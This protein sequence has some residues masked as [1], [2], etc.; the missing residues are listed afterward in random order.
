M[1]TYPLADAPVT[2]LSATDGRP[3]FIVRLGLLLPCTPEDVES[4]YR[5][6]AKLAHP[7]AGGSAAEFTQLQADYEAALEYARYHAG[8]RGWLA[9]NVER[10]SATQEVV[11]EIERLGGTVETARPA[12]IAREIGDDFAQL[13]DTITGV[14]LTGPTIGPGEVAYLAGQYVVLAGLRRLDLS[15]TRVDDLAVERLAVFPTLHELDLSGTMV[16]DR[17]VARLA[18]MPALRRVNLADTFINWLGRLRLRRRRPKL[19]IVASHRGRANGKRWY[20]W[21]LRVLVL[22]IV[23]MVLSTHIPIERELIIGNRWLSA[24]KLAHLG[25]YCGFAFLLALVVALRNVH[26]GLRAGLSRAQY[27]WIAAGVTMYAAIDELTQ[28]WT[29]RDRSFWDWVADVAGMALGLVL[30]AA[31][32]RYRQRRRELTAG[33]PE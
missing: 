9:A 26:R 16:G 15:D 19:E 13:L 20:R 27:A 33:S 2:A 11:A 8:R 22:Y 12:W 30:F 32:E 4:A 23:A 28:P 25:I 1:M 7:D 14:R 17:T 6:R 18:E 21:V 5:D 31:V 10:Y 29:G 24:D 3:D